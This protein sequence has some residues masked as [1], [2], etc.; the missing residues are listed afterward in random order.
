VFNELLLGFL[1][2]RR[3]YGDAESTRRRDRVTGS[4]G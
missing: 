3:E 2:R 4:I 1:R